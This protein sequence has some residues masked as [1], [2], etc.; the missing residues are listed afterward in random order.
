MLVQGKTEGRSG[1]NFALPPDAPAVTMNDPPDRCQPDAGTF[2]LLGRVESL[3]CAEQLAHMGHIESGT[4]VLNEVDRTPVCRGHTKL[5][6][7][8][9][10]LASE[11][12]SVTKQVLES[13]G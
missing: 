4:V 12:P 2:E 5:D 3:E 7:G 8:E 9:T 6:P 10:L 1:V 11:L 13:Y